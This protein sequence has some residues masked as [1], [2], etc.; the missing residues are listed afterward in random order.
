MY[1][2]RSK[3][4]QF[5]MLWVL[6]SA[7]GVLTIGRGVDPVVLSSYLLGG[8]LVVA[9]HMIAYGMSDAAHKGDFDSSKQ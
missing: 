9:A 1:L 6:G 3:K 5:G 7:V 4:G 8:S 2:L